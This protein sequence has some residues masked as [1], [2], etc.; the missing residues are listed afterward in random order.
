MLA[1]RS[2][3][4]RAACGSAW[5]RCGTAGREWDGRRRP[6]M[7]GHDYCDD[8]AAYLLDALRARRARGLR[9][10]P[11]RRRRLPRRGRAPARRR[12]RAPELAAPVRA[13]AGAQ[14]PHHGHR[15]RRGRAAARRRAGRRVLM[16][17]AAPPRAWRWLATGAGAGRAAARGRRPAPAR[18]CSAAAT[19]A[20]RRAA[21]VAQVIVPGARGARHARR[22]EPGPAGPG[23]HLPGVAQARGQPTRA[24]RRALRTRRDGSA[25][26]DVPGSLDD[27]EAVLVTSE[28]EGGS[29]VPTRKPVIARRVPAYATMH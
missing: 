25:S 5:R 9:G 8:V 13:A 26:V 20:S 29:Q 2:A 28:P 4:S 16:R 12:R 3:R 22:R 27:V 6:G 23:A 10:A 17:R 1:R 7:S 11:G 18:R 15:Q 24:D 21:G 14:G 19:S